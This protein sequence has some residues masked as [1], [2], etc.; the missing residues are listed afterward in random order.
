MQLLKLCYPNIPPRLIY[1][2]LHAVGGSCRA[3]DKCARVSQSRAA[4]QTPPDDGVG[5]LAP[6]LASYSPPNPARWT[7]R[8]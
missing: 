7:P 8:R 4:S 2:V 1:T 6:L 3:S 5:K